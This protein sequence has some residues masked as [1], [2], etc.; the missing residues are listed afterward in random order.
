MLSFWILKFLVLFQDS[1]FGY[2]QININIIPTYHIKSLQ[3]Q[4]NVGC[5]KN[6]GM[7][8]WSLTSEIFFFFK[9][10][11]L[12]RNLKQE[13]CLPS[14]PI[15]FFISYKPACVH[16]LLPTHSSLILVSVLSHCEKS[17]ESFP[18]KQEFALIW[19]NWDFYSN[20]KKMVR[21]KRG[22]TITISERKNRS[23]DLLHVFF[24]S[25]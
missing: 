13:N 7:N 25:I 14:W 17:T 2:L 10:P 4:Q 15:Y 23:Q 21:I 16:H 6:L 22:K 3:W 20:Y 8:L 9:A 1:C 18:Q 12:A 19:N 5:L 11:F 24:L